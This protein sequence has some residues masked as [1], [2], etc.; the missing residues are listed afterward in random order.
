[1]IA[2]VRILLP[3]ELHIPRSDGLRPQEFQHHGYRSHILPP[4]RAESSTTGMD[5]LVP[6]AIQTVEN[7]RL[8]S[9]PSVPANVFH[10]QF[11]AP[12]FDR[13]CDAPDVP[14]VVDLAF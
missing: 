2:R 10:V 14:I 13:R 11:Q 3:I 8:K 1:M 4:Y 12:D 6:A 5:R 7:V 9:E